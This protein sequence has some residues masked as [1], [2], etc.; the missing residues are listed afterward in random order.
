MIRAENITS[1]EFIGLHTEVAKSLNPQIIGLNGTVVDETKSMF[2]LDTKKGFKKIAKNQNK[3]RF[4][5]QDSSVDVD[6][7]LLAK[8]PQDRLGVR[9]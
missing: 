2:T 1:H 7:K 3:W 9:V 8:R 4:S 5:L 6:G